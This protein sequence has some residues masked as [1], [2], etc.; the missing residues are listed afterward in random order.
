MK[1][2]I[3]PEIRTTGGETT[4]L[5]HGDQ[6]IGDLYLVYREGDVLTGTAQIDTRRVS[7]KEVEDVFEEVT[8]YVRHLSAALDIEDSS[9]VCMYGDIEKILELGPIN[10]DTRIY[11]EEEE[12]IYDFTNQEDEDEI[13]RQ[14]APSIPRMKSGQVYATPISETSGYHLTISN[15]RNTHGDYFLHDDC[16][17]QIGLVTV[18]HIGKTVS[19]R[20]EFWVEPDKG[21]TN[22]VA[23]LLS[24][25]FAD[26]DVDQI[27]F[28]MNWHDQHLGDMHLEKHSVL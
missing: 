15:E 25:E 2:T 28:T 13:L 5:F 10:Q 3:K 7:E 22:E 1:V 16:D 27:T 20:V 9:V 6:W 18:D 14:E 21:E 23:R 17:N 19:G 12:E 24:K 26:G 11:E 8:H 4:G